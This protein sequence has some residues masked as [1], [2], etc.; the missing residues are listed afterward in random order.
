MTKISI[1]VAMANGNVIGKENDMPWYLPEDLKHFKKITTGHTI[2][3]GRKTFF[4]LPNGALPNRKNVVVTTDK[5]FVADGVTVV[6][7]IQEAIDVSNDNEESFV[8][9]GGNIYKQ[10]ISFVDKLYVTRIYFD[11]EGDTFFPEIEASEWYIEKEEENNREAEV[12]FKYS[13]QEYIRK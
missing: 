9:G 13:F 1:I 6:H 8:I 10:F 5:N 4:S 12:S 7:S 11:V 2:I 3:M